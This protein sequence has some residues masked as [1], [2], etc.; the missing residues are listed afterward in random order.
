MKLPM[1][2]QAEEFITAGSG[3]VKGL[4]KSAVQNILSD[5][6]IYKILAEEGGRTSRGS[7]GLMK[8]YLDFLNLALEQPETLHDVERFGS[9]GCVYFSM[10]SLF[11]CT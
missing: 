7:M 5:H 1:P 8:T 6:G 9:K 10:Q 4:G 3:Q 2:W 11:V